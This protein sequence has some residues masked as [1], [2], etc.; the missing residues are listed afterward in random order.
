MRG[1]F[2]GD[3]ERTC[4]RA[5]VMIFPLSAL[6]SI[7]KIVY[8]CCPFTFSCPARPLF[9]DL[10]LPTADTKVSR[11][12]GHRIAS[13]AGGHDGSS[14]FMAR[15]WRQ[16]H[17]V[18]NQKTKKSGPNFFI[19]CSVCTFYPIGFTGFAGVFPPFFRKG[20]NTYPVNPV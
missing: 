14:P 13:P 9:P 2:H 6:E 10:S 11:T 12:I 8:S 1:A 18:L 7:S 17:N 3:A 20:R 16:K 5:P 15:A 4:N 19:S